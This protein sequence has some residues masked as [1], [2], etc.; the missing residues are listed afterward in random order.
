MSPEFRVLTNF[1]HDQPV[2]KTASF[3]GNTQCAAAFQ[4][5]SIRRLNAERIELRPH[6]ATHNPLDTAEATSNVP[7]TTTLKKDRDNWAVLST[8]AA[9]D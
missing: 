9:T 5:E 1:H 8:G 6:L 4:I 2:S 3:A 7:M